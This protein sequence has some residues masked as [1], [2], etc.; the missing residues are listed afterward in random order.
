MAMDEFG[1]CEIF[2]YYRRSGDIPGFLIWFNVTGESE[3][4]IRTINFFDASSIPEVVMHLKLSM[5]QA[6]MEEW[7]CM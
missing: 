3:I 2:Q 1:V 5:L 7:C 6:A 4:Y